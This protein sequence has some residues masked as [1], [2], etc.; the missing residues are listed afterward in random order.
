LD[1][2]QG[3][4]GIG[5]TLVRTLVEM[6]GGT[7]T[8][9]SD[10]IGQGSEFVVRLPQLQRAARLNPGHRQESSSMKNPKRRSIRILVVDDNVEV[11]EVLTMLLDTLG[12]QAHA[13]H[14]GDSAIEAARVQVPDA[15]LLDIG[16]PGAN[17]YEVARQIRKQPGLERVL[18]VALSGYGQEEDRQRSFEAGFDEHVVKPAT[19]DVLE[20]ILARL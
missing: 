10:G 6:H 16:L 11:A 15:I 7:I 18:L 20:R 3:G 4:L 5:L 17:G 1:R 13:V 14:D 2:S 9:R 8:V 12:Y 19:V